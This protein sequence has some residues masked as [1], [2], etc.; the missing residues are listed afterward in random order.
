MWVAG[1]GWREEQG[2]FMEWRGG[3][4]MTALCFIDIKKICWVNMHNYITNTLRLPHLAWRYGFINYQWLRYPLGGHLSFRWSGILYFHQL[5]FK[6]FAYK[7]ICPM[8]FDPQPV[9]SLDLFC[10]PPLLST[11]PFLVCLGIWSYEGTISYSPQIQWTLFPQE[12]FNQYLG[13]QRKK[14]VSFCLSFRFI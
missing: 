12:S 4:G 8:R 13:Q 6:H 10:S 11:Y 14:T 5:K 7:E 2:L 1:T 3:R 9:R